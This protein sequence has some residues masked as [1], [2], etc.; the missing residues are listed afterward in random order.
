MSST[1]EFIVFDIVVKVR[2]NNGV[3]KLTRMRLA[4][5]QS[6]SLAN[7][8]RFLRILLLTVRIWSSRNIFSVLQHQE[9]N[10]K[11][12]LPRDGYA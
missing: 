6:L 5:R 11:V 2:M 12:F 8:T 1:D 4:G 10:D 3:Q 9:K 7:I